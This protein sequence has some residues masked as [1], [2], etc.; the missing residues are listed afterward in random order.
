[1]RSVSLCENKV[2]KLS[3]SEEKEFFSQLNF[4]LILTQVDSL[5]GGVGEHPTKLSLQTVQPN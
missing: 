4:P 1:M 2:P 5:G 3:N